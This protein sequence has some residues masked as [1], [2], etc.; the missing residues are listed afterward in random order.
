MKW[1]WKRKAKVEKPVSESAKSLEE[2]KGIAGSLGMQIKHGVTRFDQ[3]DAYLK[4][5]IALHPEVHD[6][7]AIIEMKK[8][9]EEYQKEV[10]QQ[11]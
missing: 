10:A 2:L 5:L 1:L 9:E 4:A 7:P 8:R 11:E 3:S 6:Q